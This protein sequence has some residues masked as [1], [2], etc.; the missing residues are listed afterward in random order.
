MTLFYVPLEPYKERYTMQWSAPKT[1]WLER[2]WIKAGIP[3]HRVDGGVASQLRTI[4]AGSVLDAVGR[5]VFA[6]SQVRE[7]L[8]LAEKGELTSQDVLYFD[9]FW[10]PGIEALPYAFHLL[11]ICPRAYAFLHAQSVDEFDFTYPMRGW[12]RYFEQGIAAYLTGIFVCC[13]TLR[14]LVVEG[15]IAPGYKVHIT[16][17]PFNSEEVRERMSPLPDWR[18]NQVV[19]SSRWDAEKNPDF[20]LAVAEAVLAKRQDVEFVVCTGAPVLR[21]NDPRLLA[22]LQDAIQRHPNNIRLCQG[23]TKE[24]YYGILTGS[25]IQMNTASQDFVAI[26][27]LEASVAGCYPIYPEFRSFP[28]TFLGRQE[29]MYRHLDVAS[30]TDKLCKVLDRDDLWIRESI[31]S[32]QWIH[33]RFDTS[34]QRMLNVM[35]LG[36]WVLDNPFVP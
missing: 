24:Q 16:G 20:F 8:Y 35:Q 19:Y 10:H 12:M 29:F 14:D 13:P 34:W 15:G 7:L 4:K 25:K 9:D 23:L 21:S 18:L 32:R 36:K 6:F 27:L 22:L 17:H 28:E 33:S 30:A 5:S 11:D 31:A 3:Y 26:T 1:G 2:N